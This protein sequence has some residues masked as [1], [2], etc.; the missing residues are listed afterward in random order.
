M[1]LYTFVITVVY[2]NKDMYEKWWKY[3]HLTMFKFNANFFLFFHITIL[4]KKK[5][6]ISTNSNYTCKWKTTMAP[7][8]ET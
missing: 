5:K 8:Q 6:E 7:R 2:E 3:L 4:L 1:Y